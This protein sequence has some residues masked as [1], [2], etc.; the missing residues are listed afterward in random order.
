MNAFIVISSA[1][2]ILAYFPLWKQIRSG[3]ARQNLL[4]WVLWCCLDGVVVATLI[5]QKVNVSLAAAYTVGSGITAVFIA[6]AGNKSSWTWFETMV[7]GLVFASMVI[8]YFSGSK[9][10]TIAGTTAMLIA[11]V[12]QLIDTWKKPQESPSLIN[13]VY[14]VANCLATAGGKSWAVEERF[15]PASAAAFCLLIAMVSLRRFSRGA[16]LQETA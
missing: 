6:K 2:A 9:M 4:T 15:Y 16:T 11:G 7:L 8:W 5:A 10:A 1:I 12:P 13:F 3:R 14:F